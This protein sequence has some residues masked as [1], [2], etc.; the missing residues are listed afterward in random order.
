MEFQRPFVGYLLISQ[1]LNFFR[2]V[3]VA[4]SVSWYGFCSSLILSAKLWPQPLVYSVKQVTCSVVRL[5][6]G[7]GLAFPAFGCLVFKN[8]LTRPSSPFSFAQNYGRV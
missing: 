4:F 7:L 6:Q 2:G 8:L 5:A 1:S 3:K